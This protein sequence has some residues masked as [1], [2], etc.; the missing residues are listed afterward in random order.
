LPLTVS[1]G[2]GGAVSTYLA[3]I[4]AAAPT[5]QMIVYGISDSEAVQDK[6]SRETSGQVADD[7]L[8]AATDGQ[9][10]GLSEK[11]RGIDPLPAAYLLIGAGDR[12]PD[13]RCRLL[14]SPSA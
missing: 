2:I 14:E 6:R 9:R 12:R 3:K 8:R 1:A 4:L 10:R 5:V 7:A 13:G 11:P